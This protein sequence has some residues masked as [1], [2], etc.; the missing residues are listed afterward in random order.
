MCFNFFEKN[1]FSY[2]LWK[3]FL[4]KWYNEVKVGCVFGLYFILFMFY[5]YV[6]FI[7]VVFKVDEGLCMIIYLFYFLFVCVN[8][9]KDL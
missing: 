1:I 8:D 9:Y 2:W 4:D 6:F 5:L 7:W 3:Y